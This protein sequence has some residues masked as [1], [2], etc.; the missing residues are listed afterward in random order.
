MRARDSGATMV[1]KKPISPSNLANCMEWL[2]RSKREFVNSP[3]YFGPD[4]RFRKQAPPDGQPE[5]R[6]EAIALTS[7][8]D[9]AMSQDD[10]DSLFG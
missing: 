4:R 6:A 1:L 10:I 9:R 2:A 7:T 3:T 5:R 8:L